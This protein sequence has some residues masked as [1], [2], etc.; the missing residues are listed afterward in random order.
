MAV[1]LEFIFAPFVI[2]ASNTENRGTS[3]SAS[4]PEGVLGV[5]FRINRCQAWELFLNRVRYFFRYTTLRTVFSNCR[6]HE[7]IGDAGNQPGQL[8]GSFDIR[9]G[10]G[11]IWLASMVANL[12]LQFGM[13]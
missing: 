13:G 7:V 6:H 11:I 2:V 12:T 5:L 3:F 10:V 8:M 4:D 9:L 1:N